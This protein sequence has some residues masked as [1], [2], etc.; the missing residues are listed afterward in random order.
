MREHK[1][2]YGIDGSFKT[3]SAGAQATVL[4]V[5]AV[6]LLAWAAVSRSRG[7]RLTAALSGAGGL[8]I[9]ASTALYIYATKVGKF[10]AWNRILEDLRLRGDETL[11]DLGCGRGAVLLAAAKRLPRGHAIGIDLWRADQTD[12]S[13]SATLKNADLE[14]VTDRIEVR[15]ADITALPFE[16][17]SV[18]VIVSSL[19]IHNIPTHAGRRQALGEAARVLRPGGRLVIADLWETRRHAAGLRELGWLDVRRRNLGWRMWYGGPWA[20]TRLVTATKP[21]A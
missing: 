5:Q 21:I 18:D 20:S 11:L 7:K 15:T 13:P 2:D 6:A 4:G 12:N 3:V 10:A 16:D 8:G 17:N 1:G 9:I 19:A 14:N